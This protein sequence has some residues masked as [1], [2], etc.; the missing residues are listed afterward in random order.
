MTNKITEKDHAELGPSS[1]DRWSACPGSVSLSRGLPNTTSFYAAEGSV[2]HEVADRVLREEIADASALLGET[3][4]IEGHS[5]TVDGEMVDAVDTYVGYVRQLAPTENDILLPEQAV[6]IGQLTGEPGAEGTSDTIVIANGGKLLHVVDL[7]YGKGVRVNAEGNGQG[8]MYALGALH[9]LSM[10]YDAIEE[11]EIHIIQPRF[12][13]GFSSEILSIGELEEFRDQVELAAGSVAMAADISEQDMLAQYLNPGEKQCKFCPAAAICPALKEW[14][15]QSLAPFS[16]S[17][18]E[19]FADLTMPKQAASLVVNEDASNEK[20]AEFLRAVPLI[21]AAITAV[22]AETER[23]LF[24]GEEI[25]G[26]YLGIGRKGDR[27]WADGA[28]ARLKKLLG[29][30]KAYEKKLIGVPAA[31]KMLK[32]AKPKVWEKIKEELIT[33]APGKPSVCMEGDKN[34][35]YIPV[36][37]ADFAD[38]SSAESEAQRLLS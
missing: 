21:E 15:S 18:A 11:V 20:L 8:R 17:S 4:E 12:E 37:A 24:L 28:E 13:D 26:F 25:P 14:A 23:R 5:I 30:G 32:K 27:K 31:E 19:D 16:S 38:L 29:A 2:A 9:K 36:T 33:Q 22:R 10:V 34:E 35:R 3:F 1:W 7:K 6:P